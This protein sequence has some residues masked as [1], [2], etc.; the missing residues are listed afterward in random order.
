MQSVAGSD[1][2]WDFPPLSSDDYWYDLGH[3][4]SAKDLKRYINALSVSDVR[5]QSVLQIAG[6]RQLR[7]LLPKFIELMLDDK[8]VIDVRYAAADAFSSVV[9]AKDASNSVIADAIEQ[10]WCSGISELR[11][12]ALIAQHVV[13]RPQALKWARTILLKADADEQLAYQ[14]TYF[15]NGGE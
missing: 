6:R 11:V 1:A 15:L 14:A 3:R 7:S 2:L 8:N 13:A 10:L 4:R 9:A 5:M 12:E